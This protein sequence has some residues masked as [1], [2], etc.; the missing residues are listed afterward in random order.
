MLFSVAL[1]AICAPKQGRLA[2]LERAGRIA[3]APCLLLM[4]AATCGCGPYMLRLLTRRTVHPVPQDEFL[5]VTDPKYNKSIPAV[6]REYED[7]G[8]VVAHW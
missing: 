5:I 3:G 6:L 1:P 4:P 7:A 2:L 8:A